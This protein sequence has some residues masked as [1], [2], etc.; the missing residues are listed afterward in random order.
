[1]PETTF[2]L[3][4]A[5]AQDDAAIRELIRLGK[6][7]PTGLHWQRF[8]VVCTPQG[9]VIACAQ[10]KPHHDGSRELASV[11]THP[12]WRGRGA[13]SM[14][15]ETLVAH[16]PAPLYLMCRA[17]LQTFYQQWGFVSIPLEAMPPYFRRVVRL[18]ST[19]SWMLPEEDR[20]VVMQRNA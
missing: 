5:A 18:F 20:L 7:N 10:I 1:M 11:A 9:E 2:S 6:I 3:R 17:A 4:H 15:I 8:W 13:A 12:Q 14:L 19:V 16:E